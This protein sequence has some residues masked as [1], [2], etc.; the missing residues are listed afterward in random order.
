MQRRQ[1]LYGVLMI[2]AIG[3]FM[4]NCRQAETV[5]ATTGPIEVEVAAVEA[6]DVPIVKE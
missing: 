4:T 3:G 2:A 1:S 5:K 6:R